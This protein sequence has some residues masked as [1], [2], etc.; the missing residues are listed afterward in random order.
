MTQLLSI[1]SRVV[2]SI[3]FYILLM[4]LII[5]S[6]PSIM[7]NTNGKIKEF[8]ISDDKTMISLGVFTVL[9]AIVSFYVFCIIDLI[10]KNS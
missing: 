9:S 6:K 5:L 7:F 1:N 4:V 10:F 3:V 2:Y 8:G